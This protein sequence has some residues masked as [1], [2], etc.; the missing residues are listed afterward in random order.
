MVLQKQSAGAPVATAPGDKPY[1]LLALLA[2]A[3]VLV[4]GGVAAYVL[5]QDPV[6]EAR[7]KARAGDMLGA[8]NILQKHTEGHADDVAA[9]A[10]LGRLYMETQQ[11]PNASTAL[12]T[13]ARL[14]PTDEELAFMAVLAAGKIPGETG[15]QRQIAVL[16]RLA[17]HH[18]DNTRA[19]RMLAL[20]QGAAGDASASAAT[21]E[22]LAQ[23]GESASDVDKF[24]GIVAAIAG[25][26]AAARAALNAAGQGDPDVQLA[27]GYVS[28]LNGDR[29]AAT[30]RLNAVVSGSQPADTE[31]RTRLG[32]LHMAQGNFD[33]ALPLLRPADS[34]VPSDSARFFYALC[35]QTAGLENDALLDYE[36]LVSAGGPFAG[37]AA[38]QMAVIYIARGQFDR[39]GEATRKARTFGNSARLYTVEG[40]ILALQ[41]DDAGAQ[42][43][44][45]K[46][47]GA[48]ESYP[49]AHLEHG[50]AYVRRGALSEGV[51]ELKRYLELV[52]DGVPGGR[53]N[54]VDLLVTQLEQAAGRE[55][56][57]S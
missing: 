35:L 50:L 44:F 42:E 51:R 36:R 21:L 54:E 13:A 53:V 2:A 20:A 46:A 7:Q 27:H 40:H 30:D 31:A 48:D 11:Y 8:V 52:K 56:T 23:A 39:A 57:A 9:F 32:L 45:R 33:A 28:S 49:A 15:Q 10:L 41:G 37:D 6:K 16:E 38:V 34:G 18:P 55:A 26:Q 25:D 43:S 24:K 3:A 19:L 29:I 14:N 17:N 47:I 22:K 5:L 4:V 1:V 12:E